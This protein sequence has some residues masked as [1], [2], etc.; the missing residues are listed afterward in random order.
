MG[1]DAHATTRVK[2]AFLAGS[3]EFLVTMDESQHANPNV[4]TIDVWWIANVQLDALELY[5]C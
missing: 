4:L 1:C 2:H 5:K 3:D